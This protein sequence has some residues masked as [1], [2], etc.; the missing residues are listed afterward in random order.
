M[1]SSTLW[2]E[3]SASIV[4]LPGGEDGLRMLDIVQEWTECWMLKPAFWV[5]SSEEKISDDAVPRITTCVIGRNGRRDIDLLDYLSREDFDKVRLIAIRTVDESGEHD[6]FQDK[7]VDLVKD[8]L[9]SARP[10]EIKANRADR[11]HTTLI[12][13]NLVFAPTS[14]TGA[15]SLHLL[16]PGWD[17][18]LVVAPEDRSTPSRFDKSTRDVTSSDKDVW[19]R[20]I[21]SNTAVV[22]GIWA[23]QEKGSLET[24]HHFQDL[25][26]VQGQVRLMRSFVRGVLSEGLS[27]RVA[28]EA[29][30][31][32]ANAG[33]SRID[34][35]R[36]YPNNFLE[37]YETVRVS[38]EINKMVDLSIGFSKNRLGYSRVTLTPPPAPE[39]I[40]NFGAVKYF[41]KTT[42]SL[43]KVLPLW[44]FAGIWNGLARFISKL[45]FG[46]RGRK[47]VKGN[48]DFKR[49]NLDQDADVM[50]N[51]I[52]R[53]RKKIKEILAHWPNNVLRKSEPILWSEI[54]KLVIGRLDASALPAGLAADSGTKGKLVIGD[55]NEVVPDTKE[56]WFL[57]SNFERTIPSQPRS[58]T[59]LE[60]DVINDLGEFL[61]AEISRETA[62]I[63]ELRM[64]TTASHES[65][66]K[67]EEELALLISQVENLR[68][69]KAGDSHE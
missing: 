56:K 48:V 16:E 69:S 58:A 68:L 38:E 37:A 34:P 62:A 14:R 47:V 4:L 6:T 50:I 3:G 57:P 23:G 10:L 7:I 43:F 46:L 1:S 25:S 40:G 5:Y 32:A 53:R 29:L 51:E 36:S 21:L 54:R 49:T 55:L 17:I 15:S 42:W 44:I 60:D 2:H 66:L 18:N 26:P 59:W 19:H 27:T 65:K 52:A 12:R 67:K 22:G 28:A 41:F 39:E 9:E 63:E 8:A 33:K 13:V 45:I 35:L 11:P 61:T 31:R 30:S 24:S 20:F 64:K